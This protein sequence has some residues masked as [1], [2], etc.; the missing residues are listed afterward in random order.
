MK[1]F[2]RTV[3]AL[4]A[5]CL[6]MLCIGCG[7]DSLPVSDQP[8][9]IAQVT[10]AAPTTTVDTSDTVTT[11]TTDAV[12]APTNVAETLAAIPEYDGEP[13]VMINDNEPF[14]TKD[15][16]SETSFEDYSPLD[17]LGRCGVATACVGKDIMPTDERESIASVTPSGWHN[18]TYDFVDGGYVYNR[19]HLIGFQL[20]GENAN[21]KNLITGTRYFNIDGM[22]PFE[23]MIADYIY[24]TDNHVMLR[25]TPC[26]DGSNLMASGVLME[27]YSIED[28]GEGVC[29]NVYVYNVQPGV[30]IDYATGHNYA[31]DE[32]V[33]TQATAV[34]TTAQQTETSASTATYVLNTNTKKIH[35]PSCQHAK[36]IK[37]SNY[38]TSSLT[39]AELE[40]QGYVCCKVCF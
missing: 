16:L 38:A 2:R 37:D 23:N 26:Y 33:T 1:F 20:T 32:A 39:I 40:A 12:T 25:V 9:V 22:L 7:D 14:F 3:A 10:T 27:A 4:S 11:V 15:E 31:A 18:E 34:S 24:E 29:F 35:H 13:F 30:I 8:V 19:C 28:D 17:L 5:L 36:K 6:L 21:E